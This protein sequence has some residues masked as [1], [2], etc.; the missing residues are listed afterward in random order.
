MRVLTTAGAAVYDFLADDAGFTGGVRVA[1]RDVNGDGKADVIT[2]GG[3]GG[4]AH[5]Q[6]YS[7]A[8]LGRL[9]DFYAFDSGVKTGVYVG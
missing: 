3:V 2:G 8:N 5:V 4:F 7:G 9:D 6:V 1:A